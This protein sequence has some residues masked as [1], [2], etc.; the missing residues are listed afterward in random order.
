VFDGK[1]TVM[2]PYADPTVSPGRVS[3]GGPAA[4]PRRRTERKPAARR[5]A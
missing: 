2:N 4:R 3:E 1:L 5:G